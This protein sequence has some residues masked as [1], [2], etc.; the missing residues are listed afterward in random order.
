MNG[1]DCFDKAFS[2]QIADFGLGKLVRGMD[3]TASAFGT[4]AYAA[5][6]VPPAL[7]SSPTLGCLP[8]SHLLQLITKLR[9]SLHK[10][11]I[12][13]CISEIHAAE[14]K[15]RTS[16]LNKERVIESL[17]T[18]MCAGPDGKGWICI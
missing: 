18:C 12:P 17:V 11:C 2:V 10:S 7:P 9:L 15:Q 8:L 5:P 13:Q 3:V 14:V 16:Y 6:E 4:F 1:T